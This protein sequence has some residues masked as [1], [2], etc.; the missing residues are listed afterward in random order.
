MGCP[1]DK[2]VY[3]CL[4]V[5]LDWLQFGLSVYVFTMFIIMEYF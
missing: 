1:E 2:K 4:N 3:L 5:V